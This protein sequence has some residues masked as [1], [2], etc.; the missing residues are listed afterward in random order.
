MKQKGI[1]TYGACLISY[2][3][4]ILISL[5]LLFP[6]S[7]SV[8]LESALRSDATKTKCISYASTNNA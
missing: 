2:T 4:L 1:V 5:L 7:G 3:C 8:T 6:R